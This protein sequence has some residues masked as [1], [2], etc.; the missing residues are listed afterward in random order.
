MSGIGGVAR[1]GAES[2]HDEVFDLSDTP[3]ARDCCA[4]L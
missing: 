3:P 1:K 4:E 2:A